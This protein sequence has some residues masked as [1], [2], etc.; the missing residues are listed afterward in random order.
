MQLNQTVEASESSRASCS[1]KH[2][3]CDS[4]GHVGGIVMASAASLNNF[5][6]VGHNSPEKQ[7]K[8]TELS[9]EHTYIIC[10]F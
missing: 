1:L 4:Q 3:L 8:L 2:R 5:L 6:L 10:I 9:Y 7:Q